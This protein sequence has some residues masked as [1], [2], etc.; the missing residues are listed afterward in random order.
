MTSRVL[1]SVGVVVSTMVRSLNSTAARHGPVR[2]PP[3][4]LSGGPPRSFHS[5]P[6]PLLGLFT[7]AKP[8]SPSA[9][10]SVPSSGDRKTSV[11]TVKG[12]QPSR[13]A[14]V[15]PSSSP[16]SPSAEFH[17]M[18]D[19]EFFDP[20]RPLRWLVAMD[21]SVNAFR[22][23]KGA[24]QLMRRD[25]GDSLVVFSVPVVPFLDPLNDAHPFYPPEVIQE[26]VDR[27]VKSMEAVHDE[28]RDLMGYYS[29]EVSEPA[30]DPRE[31]VLMRCERTGEGRVDYAVCGQRGRSRLLNILLGSV[32]IHLAHYSPTSVVIIK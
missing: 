4:P 20:R 25:R 13:P 24:K 1:R 8:S 23:L 29:C 12:D 32:A 10:N 9:S 3:L 26:A 27:A 6:P 30:S 15:G 11:V 5:T 17:Q 31:I 16:N 21:F 14:K 2:L 7:S 28:C 19:D 18:S 22:A